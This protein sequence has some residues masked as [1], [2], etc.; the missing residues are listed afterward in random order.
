[1]EEALE[2]KGRWKIQ[3]GRKPEVGRDRRRDSEVGKVRRLTGA[4]M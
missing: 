3:M 2:G 4:E 1:M